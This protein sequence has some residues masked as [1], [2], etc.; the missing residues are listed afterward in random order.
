MAENNSDYEY[1][2][3]FST[4]VFVVLPGQSHASPE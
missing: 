3:L 1:S 4:F 2:V